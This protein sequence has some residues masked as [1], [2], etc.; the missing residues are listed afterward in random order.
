MA[1]KSELEKAQALLEES[2]KKILDYE[3]KVKDYTLKEK[4][5]AVLSNPKYSALPKAYKN[6]VKASENEQ[7]ILADAELA[8]EQFNQDFQITGQTFGKPNV[9]KLPESKG[10]T[11]LKDANDLKT[12]L[13]ERMNFL[14][15]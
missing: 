3:N 5:D 14:K 1:E 7:D 11:P 15:I 2:N 13:K 12:R 4:K 6:M 9:P 10:A 8:L